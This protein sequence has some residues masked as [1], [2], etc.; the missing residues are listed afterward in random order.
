MGWEE[1]EEE[2]RK[3]AL[4]FK[5]RFEELENLKITLKEACEKR[6]GK[7]EVVDSKEICKIQHGKYVMKAVIEKRDGWYFAEV[8]YRKMIPF[9]VSGENKELIE[10]EVS[11]F[12]LKVNLNSLDRIAEIMKRKSPRIIL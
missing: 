3:G 6:G 12:L 9:W 4:R 10:K 2:V 1:W 7:F 5:R 8:K 11:R